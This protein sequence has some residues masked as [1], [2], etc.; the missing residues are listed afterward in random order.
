[1][2]DR[3]VDSCRP[4]LGSRPRLQPPGSP[5]PRPSQNQ[6]RTEQV[7]R[8]GRGIA[9][10]APRSRRR[11]DALRLLAEMGDVQGRLD[12]L[13]RRLLELAEDRSTARPRLPAKS[14]AT[15]TPVSCPGAS[16]SLLRW[17]AVAPR[18]APS[19]SWTARVGGWRCLPTR[20]PAA[21]PKAAQTW[22]QSRA[23]ES[24]RVRTPHLCRPPIG[25]SGW[26]RVSPG[27]GATSRP[28]RRPSS[29]RPKGVGE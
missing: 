23:D 4:R 3:K 16:M 14:Q 26:P 20:D 18:R 2:K 19:G 24:G 27:P 13:T 6:H 1:M 12:D 10:T 15:H 7:R 17:N 11:E 22:N 5:A 25:A 28:R 29:P 9:V 8:L 21:P